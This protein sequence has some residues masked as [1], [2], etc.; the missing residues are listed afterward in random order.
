MNTDGIPTVRSAPAVLGYG[1][2]L[3]VILAAFSYTGGT[4][5][6]YARDPDLD[7]VARKEY[8]RKNRRRPIEETINELGEGRGMLILW[9]N[10]FDSSKEHDSDVRVGR[11]ELTRK[12]VSTRQVTSKGEQS[13]SR[14][15]TA[16]TCQSSRRRRSLHKPGLRRLHEDGRPCGASVHIHPSSRFPRVVNRT[17]NFK[18]KPH[19]T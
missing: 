7:E 17:S 11:F 18:E 13:A 1:T 9:R 2:A 14:S 8:L 3:S 19:F 5:S 15:D 10:R 12:Q 6:G 16:S 4:L